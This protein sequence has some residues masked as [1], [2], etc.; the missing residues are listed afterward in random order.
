VPR[1]IPL[2]P[3]AAWV[4]SILAASQPNGCS[5]PALFVLGETLPGAP[6]STQRDHVRHGIVCR[7]TD[8]VPGPFCGRWMGQSRRGVTRLRN[9]GVPPHFR[10]VS[11]TP[12]AP[13]RSVLLNSFVLQRRQD[14]SGTGGRVGIGSARMA[15]RTA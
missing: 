1:G 15:D 12:R 7:G 11:S 4:G 2:P 9:A 13:N 8:D 6:K 5:N 3:L 14:D 10:R